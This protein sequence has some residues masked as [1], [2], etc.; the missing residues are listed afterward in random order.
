MIFF[1]TEADLN[2]QSSQCGVRRE[3][4]KIIRHHNFEI[5]RGLDERVDDCDLD[6]REENE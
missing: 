2:E 6:Y 4:N 5:K 3:V 1:A